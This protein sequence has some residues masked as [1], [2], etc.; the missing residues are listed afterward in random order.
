MQ[1]IK[2]TYKNQV[3]TSLEDSGTKTLATAGKY[4]DGNIK[5]TYTK[6]TNTIVSSSTWYLDSNNNLVM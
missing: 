3:I 4:C 2:V 5:I 1:D 6:A